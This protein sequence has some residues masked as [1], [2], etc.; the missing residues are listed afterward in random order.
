MRPARK[1]KNQLQDIT[2]R[3]NDINMRGQDINMRGQDIN[4]RGNPYTHTEEGRDDQ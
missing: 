1:K 2:V 4:V 3:G